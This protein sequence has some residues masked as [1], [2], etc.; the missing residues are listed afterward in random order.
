MP[1]LRCPELLGHMLALRN[2]SSKRVLG[3]ALGSKSS[4]NRWSLLKVPVAFH[5]GDR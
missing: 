1:R 5:G 3:C 4:E 2:R